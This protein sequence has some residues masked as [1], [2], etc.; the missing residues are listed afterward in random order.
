MV[1]IADYIESSGGQ[2][3]AYIGHDVMYYRY[4]NRAFLGFINSHIPNWVLVY[5]LP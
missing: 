3:H 4:A 2:L 5:H 1:I